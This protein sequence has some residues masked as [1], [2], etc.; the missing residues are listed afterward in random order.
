MSLFWVSL[1]MFLKSIEVLS[2]ILFWVSLEVFLKRIEVPSDI[3][4]SP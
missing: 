1:E 4:L 2:V 3:N